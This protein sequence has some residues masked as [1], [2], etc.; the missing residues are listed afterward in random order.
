MWKNS[1]KIATLVVGI[2]LV[3]A[4]TVFGLA[5]SIDHCKPWVSVCI[6]VG[7]VWVLVFGAVFAAERSML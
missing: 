2:S 1:A 7:V 4:S 6:L 3:F 5:Y